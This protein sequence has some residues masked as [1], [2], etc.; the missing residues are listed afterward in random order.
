MTTLALLSGGQASEVLREALGE[1]PG[2]V[3]GIADLIRDEVTARGAC[4]RAATIR[5]LCRFVSPAVALD[6]A[7]VA[8]VCDRL[9][10]DGDLVLAVGGVLYST[11][12][13]A[14][15]LGQGVLRF[16]S[17]LSTRRLAAQV[18]GIWTVAATSRTCQVADADQARAAIVAAGG[19]LITPSDWASLERTPR[20]DQGW[21]D[22]LE[23]RLVAEPETPAS[24][25]RD[26]SLVWSGCAVTDGQ[27]RWQAKGPEHATRLWR[28]RNR[29]G[30]W[31]YAWTEQGT[32]GVAPFVSLRPDEGVRTV[33]ALARALDA[34]LVA[35]ISRQDQA[36][37]LCVSQWLPVAEYRFLAICASQSVV[38]RNGSRWSLP[39][40]RVADV[41]EVLGE[42][43]GLV[44]DEESSG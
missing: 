35:S 24:L 13:R 25:E 32:P 38:D 17:S 10:R 21:L 43:L 31:H 6:E 16:A 22:A 39:I 23:R 9:E 14:I 37:V 33:F 27:I 30:Y 4:P 29:W 11:P 12:L 36:A 44:V 34:P 28:A 2:Q 19:I 7:L 8:E 15:D 18:I 26:E 40:D 41:I 20:A 42:R 3:E 5:R 1:D